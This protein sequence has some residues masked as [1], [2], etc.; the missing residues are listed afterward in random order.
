MFQSP[1]T[2]TASRYNFQRTLL[3]FVPAAETTPMLEVPQAPHVALE[4]GLRATAK[5]GKLGRVGEDLSSA[6]IQCME[7]ESRHLP[8][9][10]PKC[11]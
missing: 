9:K 10:S 11:R 1:P 4:V 7:Y 3:G 2:R 5:S 6:D 8:G